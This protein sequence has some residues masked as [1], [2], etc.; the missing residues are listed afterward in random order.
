GA[1]DQ[2]SEPILA[3]RT[4]AAYVGPTAEMEIAT[5]QSDELGCAQPGLDGEDEECIVA[6]PG[7]CGAVWATKDCSYLLA[8]E[9]ANQCWVKSLRRNSEYA[10]DELGVF[11]VAEGGIAIERMDGGQ[12][13]VARAHAVP[14][15][16][17]QVV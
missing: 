1:S 15:F 17:L 11:G 8:G 14:S 10:L 12:S 3:P 4:A 2:R 13:R 7:P 5:G 16:V 6:T 9:K